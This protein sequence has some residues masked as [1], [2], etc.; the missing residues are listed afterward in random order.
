M[1]ALVPVLSSVFLPTVSTDWQE[2]RTVKPLLAQNAEPITTK[3]TTATV[4]EI[5]YPH[6]N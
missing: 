6:S 3:P 4:I 5:N 1:F 2:K